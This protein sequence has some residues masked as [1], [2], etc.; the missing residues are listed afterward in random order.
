MAV[1]LFYSPT[2]F[3]FKQR[4]PSCFCTHTCLRYHSFSNICIISLPRISVKFLFNY[5]DIIDWKNEDICPVYLSHNL[6]AK[7]GCLAVQELIIF[8][9]SGL[10]SWAVSLP[11]IKETPSY[12][13]GSFPSL[14][15]KAE[16]ICSFFTSL[17]RARSGLTFTGIIYYT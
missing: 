16:R 15:C 1:A 3:F 8:S 4:P 7:D 11:E 13:T 17:F 9:I 6:V 12:L 10:Q 2:F 14:N 5:F